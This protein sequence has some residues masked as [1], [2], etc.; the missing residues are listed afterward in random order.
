MG[1][2]TI[3]DIN[4]NKIIKLRQNI[5]LLP[6]F[7]YEYFIELSNTTSINTRIGYSY[8]LKLFFEYLIN[9]EPMFYKDNIRDFTFDDFSKIQARHIREFLD[10][11]SYYIRAFDTQSGNTTVIEE[12]NGLEGKSRKL[13]AIRSIFLFFTNDEKIAHNPAS[14]VKT[15]K[16]HEKHIT[17]LDVNEVVDLLDEIDSGENLTE[18]QK[19]Y[20]NKT[21]QRDLTLVMLILGTGMRISECV[22]IDI[23]KIDFQNSCI[24]ITRKGGKESRVYFNEE[25]EDVLYDHIDMQKLKFF[26]QNQTSKKS[27]KL[28]EQEFLETPLF[29][30]LQNKRIGIRTVQN[31]VKKYSKLST[32]LKNIS[33]HKLRSTYATNLYRETNDIYLVA[34]ALGHADINTTKRHY[35]KMDDASRRRASK[36]V[37]LRKE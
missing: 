37:K 14:L 24:L 27:D 4:K 30:S 20:H 1:R 34:D 31:L 5:K 26:R 15:P 29:T 6:D 10:Y 25:I 19:Q 9:E 17:Y 18:K 8:D 16:K 33:P 3:K 11:L 13:S 2:H 36:Y 23:N 7:V 12:T 35:A 21:R 28:L 22:S 32:P